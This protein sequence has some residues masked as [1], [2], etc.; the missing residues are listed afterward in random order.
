MP[1]KVRGINL[2]RSNFKNKTQSLN[3][4]PST[5]NIGNT[6]LTNN[7]QYNNLFINPNLTNFNVLILM[8]FNPFLLKLHYMTTQ[9]NK[10]NSFTT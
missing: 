10:L 8:F 6:K 2:S 1:Y 4:L 9:A 5:Y 7:L 3:S